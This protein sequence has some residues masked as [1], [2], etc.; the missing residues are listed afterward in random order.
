MLTA[1]LLPALSLGAIEV[2]PENIAALV[3]EKNPEVEAS[4]LKSEAAKGRDGYWLRSF[5]PSV[6]LFGAQEKFKKGTHAEKDQPT[7]G[8]TLGVNLF[9]GGRDFLEGKSRELEVEGRSAA[10]KRTTAESIER[11]RA[12]FWHFIYWREKAG[13]LREARERNGGNLTAAEKRIKGG[14]AT[15]SDRFEFEMKGVDLSR[16][17]GRAELEMRNAERSLK[18]ALGTEEELK[19]PAAMNHDHSLVERIQ[20]SEA[21]HEFLTKEDLVAAERLTIEARKKARDWWPRLDAYA[22]FYQFNEREE[23]FANRE[24]RKESVLGLKLSV[25]FAAGAESLVEAKALR[26]EAKASEAI[27]R[28]RESEVHAHVDKDLDELKF[29]HQQVHEAEKNIERAL[30][31]YRMTQSEYGRGVKNSPDVL[32]AAEKLF[33][34]Q[35]RRIEIIRDYELAKVHFLGSIGR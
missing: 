4:R 30:G 19:F 31:Y 28:Y 17:L 15:Q 34:M 5:L 20:H 14:V 24:Q 33:D 23:E 29:L 7:Y 12:A 10:E 25:N 22:G 6:E 1:I 27:G 32:G 2:N 3:A 9:N 13:L 11:A 35:H 16:E 18:I 8:A 21:D 26:F